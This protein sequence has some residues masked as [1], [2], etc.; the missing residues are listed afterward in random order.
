MVW[1]AAAPRAFRSEMLVV[2]EAVDRTRDLASRGGESMMRRELNRVGRVLARSDTIIFVGSGVSAWSGL[3]TWRALL[4]QLRAF[5]VDAGKFDGLVARELQNNDL[6]LAASYGFDQLTRQERCEFLRE[7]VGQQSAEVSPLHEAVVGLGSRCYITTNYDNLI[8]RALSRFRPDEAFNVVTPLQRL[9]VASI[10]QARSEGFVFKPHGDLGSCDSIVLTRE[11]YRALHAQHRNVLEATRTLLASRPVVFIGFGLRDPDFLLIQDLLISAFG[12]NPTDHYAIVPDALPTETDYWRRNYGIHLVTYRTAS[13]STGRDAHRDLLD[14][15]KGIGSVAA[16]LRQ[17]ASKGHEV[18]PAAAVD[19]TSGVI[20]GLARHARRLRSEISAVGDPMPLQFGRTWTRNRSFELDGHD[21]LRTIS[22]ASFSFV[23]EGPPGSGK[24]FVL[25]QA[26][27]LLAER[28]EESCL[29]QENLTIDGLRV[30][31]LVRLRDY[32]GDLEKMVAQSLPLD[33][34]LDLLFE[35]G[36]GIFLFDGVNEVPIPTSDH[37]EFMTQLA[38]FVGRASSCVSILTTR[39]GGELQQIGLPIVTLDEISRKYVLGRLVDT[40]VAVGRVPEPSISLLQRPLYF[41]AWQDGRISLDNATDVHSIYLQLVSGLEKEAEATVGVPVLFGDAFGSLAFEMIDTGELSVPLPRVYVEMHSAVSG[42]AKVDHLL[43]HLISSGVLIATPHRRLTFFHHSLTEYIA[44]Q[45]LAK[46]VKVD[47]GMIR[48]CLR[49]RDWDQALLLTLGFLEDDQARDAFDEVLQTDTAA[50]LRAVNYVE[51]MRDQWIEVALRSLI[52]RPA[53][54]DS[55]ELAAAL[56]KVVVSPMHADALAGVVQ[57][58]NVLGGTAARLLWFVAPSQRSSLLEYLLDGSRGYNFLAEFASGIADHVTAEEALKVLDRAAD[59]PMPHETVERLWKGEEVEELVPIIN[60]VQ[61]LIR[62]IPEERILEIGRMASSILARVIVAERVDHS[63]TPGALTYTQ[64]LIL[65]G[66]KYAVVRFHFQLAF[67]R[68]DGSVAASLRPDVVPA[69]VETMSQGGH[70]AY[71]AVEALKNVSAISPDLVNVV[72][73]QV[74]DSRLVEAL[75]A[76]ITG[77]DGRFLEI[78]DGMS[79]DAVDWWGEP[80]EALK[81]VKVEWAGREEVLLRLLALKD[82]R[83]A[84]AVLES[85]YL[86]PERAE[87]GWRKPACVLDDLDW[88]ISWLGEIEPDDW[89]LRDRLGHFL[90]AATAAETRNQL[91][92]RFN[93]RPEYREVLSESVLH[94]MPD[95]SLE[96][97]AQDAVEWLIGQLSIARFHQF[98]LPLIGILATEEV[99][100]ERLLPLLLS[101]PEEPLRSNLML[102]LRVTGDRHRRRYVRDDGSPLA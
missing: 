17:V 58:G 91:I 26:T 77:D 63:C 35:N 36:T 81:Y 88:W 11:G 95:L 29:T 49:K 79:R 56:G 47:R 22:V 44:A 73:A 46:L 101:E 33:V 55:F 83:V 87:A 53:V 2:P 64:N 71:W 89:L 69:L 23:I 85:I 31:V 43:D 74:T 65:A 20:L 99:V 62:N 19:G 48:R 94:R 59:L 16:R 67:G 84:V 30:P 40:G 1:F 10:V 82:R 54:G 70:A 25:E 50:A 9:E 90:V 96:H 45:Y 14:L 100:Q 102:T 21:P 61:T 51:H 72:A 38:S 24:S 57:I 4:G 3:P 34:D 32:T 6:L 86:S 66:E 39:F 75:I 41:R 27:R 42:E 52:A 28:L 98:E 97:L 92:D 37:S 12:T 80:V 68:P 7:A 93:H 78:L 76:H 15:V 60:S 5:M 8:E 13:D 18:H